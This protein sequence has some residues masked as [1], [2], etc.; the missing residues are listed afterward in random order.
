MKISILG[1]KG[2]LGSDL[3]S[4]LSDKGFEASV[5]DL[6]ECDIT[7]PEHLQQACAY[8]DVIVNC[9][10]YTQ[11]DK[12]EDEPAL[13]AAVNVKAVGRLGELAADSGA[14]IVHISTDF[15]FDGTVCKPYKETDSPCPLSVYGKTKLEGEQLLAES[16]CRHAIMR[17]EW[18]YGKNGVNFISK[19]SER[20][21]TGADLKVVN[22]QIGAPTWT[23][24]MA[25]AIKCLITGKH[26]GLYHFAAAGYASRFNVARFIMDKLGLN[27][28]VEPCSSS[29][30]PV[31]AVRPAN[32]IFDTEKIQKLLDFEI[33]TWQTALS[34]FLTDFRS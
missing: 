14:Y 19:L 21:G 13:A 2:M 22:D 6:P 28:K 17:V 24:D 11:V 3:G 18:S 10:A 1:G 27:N 31:K 34:E 30:F 15:V 23:F 25:R 16:G 5:Y 8:S 32:S 26:E 20:A 33:R 7:R 9:A 4:I 12:A 29:D